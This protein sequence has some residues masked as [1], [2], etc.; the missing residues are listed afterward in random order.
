[1]KLNIVPARTGLHWVRMGIR[2]F[3]RQPLAM[4]GLFFMFMA[5]MSVVSMVP[6]LGSALVLGLLPAATFGFMAATEQA[7]KGEFPMPWILASALRAGRQELHAILTLGALYA[8]SFMGVMGASALVDSGQFAQ[9]YLGGAKL[10]REQLNDA[11]F[12]VAMWI[13]LGLNLPLSLLFWHAPALVHWHGIPP[14]KALF[15]SF[16]ACVRNLGA[17]LVFSLAWSGIFL[18][19]IVAGIGTVGLL[20]G[21]E[22]AGLAMAPAAMLAMAL[23]FTSL[24]FTFADTFIATPNEPA[25]E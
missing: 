4:T 14:V 22:A 23:F 24:Y 12:Q 7:S 19:T 11:N 20:A 2:T 15:F 9:F 18:V 13:T 8:L 10:S 17:Y 1:M 6:Y 3:F 5:V 21:P 16:V 25:K